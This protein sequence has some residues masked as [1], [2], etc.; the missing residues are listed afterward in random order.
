M[1]IAILTQ[2]LR[3]NYGGILQNF[4]LQ[5]VLRRMGHDVVTLDPQRYHYSR[6]RY[7]SYTYT[8]LWKRFISNRL[9]GDYLTKRR[10]FLYTLQVIQ[11]HSLFHHQSCNILR[12]KDEDRVVRT[13]G[14]YTFPFIN[15]YIKR[16]EY[17]ILAD[18]IKSSEYDAFIVG[19]D[20]IWRPEY[21]PKINDLFLEFTRSWNVKRIAYAASF[22]LDSWSGEEEMTSIG[23]QMLKK[24][25]SVSVREDSGVNICKEIFGVE[26]T[27]VLDPTL[28]LT[29]EDYIS[30]LH[31]DNLPKSNGNLLIYFLDNTED[32]KRLSEYIAKKYN[33]IPFRV[34]SDVEDGK[35][36]LQDRIQPALE[37]W[38]RGFY[39][40]EYVI[41]DSF[42]GCVFSLIF[43]KSFVVYGNDDRGNARFRSLLK[44]FSLTNCLVSSSDEFISFC[45]YQEDGCIIRNRDKS[46]AYLSEVLNC[47]YP[48]NE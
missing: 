4:A 9:K 28:L 13:L 47:S 38:L 43:G 2:P 11:N 26:A 32:K 10:I 19:S 41:T 44:Q 34:G 25:D 14:K 37:K 24:F 20:Q 48:L 6:W 31:I 12:R 1:R 16:K 27:H 42:H 21:N 30:L 46:L 40:A 15:R 17:Q 23:R 22:G 45:K 36:N 8:L 29:K 3:F 39:D 33:L 35:A 7:L 5:T 18:E